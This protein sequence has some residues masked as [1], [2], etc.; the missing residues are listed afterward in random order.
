MPRFTISHHTGPGAKE[1]YDFMLERE[2]ALQTWRIQH[3]SFM[4][5][6]T[7]VQIRDH[8]KIYLDFEGEI[9]GKRGRL[10][11]WDTGTFSFDEDGP[12]RLRVALAGKQVRTRLIFRKGPEAPD[13]EAVPWTVEDASTEV[14][15]LASLLL[16]GRALEDAPTGELAPLREALLAEEQKILSQ[17]DRYSHGAPVEWPLLEPAT[18]VYEKIDREKSRWQ[19][20]WLADAKKYADRLAE[21]TRA[22]R[23][24]QPS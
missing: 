2:E 5:P 24:Q 1:H 18:E 8:R 14:R 23:Q 13:P 15:K 6:Q 7:A 11:L 20:P 9:P 21:L 3:T 19:H 16:R 17:V 4:T 10:S 12:G 22:L